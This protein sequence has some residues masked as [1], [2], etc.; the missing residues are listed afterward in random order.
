MDRGEPE[1]GR[2]DL[3]GSHLL[4]LPLLLLLL[5]DLPRKA[6]PCDLVSHDEMRL[7]SRLSRIPEAQ[8]GP[9]DSPKQTALPISSPVLLLFHFPIDIKLD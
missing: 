3:D 7:E 4:L 8:W 1:V 5:P 2:I 9:T 6:D